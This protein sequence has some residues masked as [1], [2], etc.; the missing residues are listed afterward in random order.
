MGTRALLYTSLRSNRVPYSIAIP[1]DGGET[2]PARRRL[3][4]QRLPWRYRPQHWH[5]AFH[6]RWWAPCRTAYRAS[7]ACRPDLSRPPPPRPDR[8]PTLAARKRARI[9]MGTRA[10]LYTSLRS[11][12]VPYS[13][14]IPGDGGETT[15][16]RRRLPAQRLP[17]RYRPQHWHPAFHHRWWAPCRTAYR[18]S[19]A[20][21][22]CP[23]WALA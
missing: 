16:A 3:P 8:P 1:G 14:A 23:A 9:P 13:I 17:W 5:P 21:R 7:R 18:A 6:H 12:R 22:D 15:P 20:C 2:T 19:R 10:L 11:N 4:A